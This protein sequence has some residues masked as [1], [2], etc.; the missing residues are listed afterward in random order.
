MGKLGHC[1]LFLPGRQLSAAI[2]LPFLS[3]ALQAMA[4]AVR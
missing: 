3:H 4:Q 1:G 2:G